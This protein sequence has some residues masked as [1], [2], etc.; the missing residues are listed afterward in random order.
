M[1]VF[2]DRRHL[3]VQSGDGVERRRIVVGHVDDGGDAAGNGR[4]GCRTDARQAAIGAGVRLAID[5]AGNDQAFAGIEGFRC[6]RRGAGTDGGDLAG[7]DGDPGVFER[8]VGK[9]RC[10]ADDE[11]ECHAV[12]FR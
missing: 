6:L 10:A 5:D 2:A 3:V 4:A 8:A 11:I 9:D 7:G 1:R 12:V